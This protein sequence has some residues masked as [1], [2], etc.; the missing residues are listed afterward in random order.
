MGGRGHVVCKPCSG[1][2]GAEAGGVVGG[3]GVGGMVRIP[4]SEKTLG[5][6]RARLAVRGIVL[7]DVQCAHQTPS[8]AKVYR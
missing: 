1:A 8:L 3:G 2:M 6:S 7:D 4:A 5:A